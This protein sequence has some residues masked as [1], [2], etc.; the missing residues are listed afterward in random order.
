MQAVAVVVGR[1][2]AKAASL[3]RTP[4]APSAERRRPASTAEQPSSR[5]SRQVAADSVPDGE[6]EVTGIGLALAHEEGAILAAVQQH[7]LRLYSRDVGVEPPSD[8][9][10]SHGEAA[11]T[12]A[13][14]D[15][16]GGREPSLSLSC[17][18]W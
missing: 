11:V 17:R 1:R 8:R 18:C 15:E 12:L 7:A 10:A 2:R 3:P 9:R 13:E 16:E 4:I 14:A 5:Q 6:G